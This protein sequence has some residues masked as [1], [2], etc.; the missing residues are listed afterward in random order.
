MSGR[1]VIVL[2]GKF[3]GRKAV[4]VRLYDGGRGDR[5]FSHAL[6]E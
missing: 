1:I 4:I 6:G 5:K 2:R 3:A